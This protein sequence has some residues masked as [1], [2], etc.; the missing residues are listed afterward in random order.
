MIQSFSGSRFWRPPELAFSANDLRFAA[1][2]EPFEATRFALALL[3][4]QFFAWLGT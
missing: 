2:F 1:T 3:R 4:E